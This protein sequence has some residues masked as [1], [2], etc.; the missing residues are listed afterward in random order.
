MFAT[1]L[2]PQQWVGTIADKTVSPTH[3]W[4]P[5]RDTDQVEMVFGEPMY[6]E[7]DS[8]DIQTLR[9]ATDRIMREI[10]RLSGQEYVEM[11]ASEAKN[12]LPRGEK[13]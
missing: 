8:T 6:F 3:R 10:Q 12:K 9:E 13:F 2:G 5:A 11:Y 1:Y 4:L 7:R